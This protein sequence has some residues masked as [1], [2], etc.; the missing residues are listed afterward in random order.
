MC[1]RNAYRRTASNGLQSRERTHLYGQV[2]DEYAEKFP[3][4][5]PKD[6][7][8]AERIALYETSFLSWFV[9]PSTVV[10]EIGPGV[11]IWPFRSRP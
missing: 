5:L 3:E 8:G 7:T 1:L 4:S 10:L 2:Y 11:A 6:G 9:T